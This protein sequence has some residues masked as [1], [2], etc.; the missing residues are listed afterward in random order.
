MNRSLP[1]IPK[2]WIQQARLADEAAIEKIY[3]KTYPKAYTIAYYSLG[4]TNKFQDEAQ[5]ITQDSLRKAFEKLSLLK[6]DD[7]FAPWMYTILNNSIRDYFRSNKNKD[8]QTNTFSELDSED[9]RDNYEESI[10]DDSVAFSPEANMNTELIAQ[11]L[12]ECLDQL[13]DNQRFAL[14]MQM[15]QQ[16][17]TKEIAKQ[18]EVEENTVKSWIRRAK[19]SIKDRIEE[20]RSQ[21]KSFYGVA[22]LPF[23]AWMLDQE[24]KSVPTINAKTFADGVVLKIKADTM[25]PPIPKKHTNASTKGEVLEKGTYV[26]KVTTISEGHAKAI[27]S[28]FWKIAAGAAIVTAATVG[29]YV[30]VDKIMSDKYNST[31]ANERISSDQKIT[32]SGR[33][34]KIKSEEY[35]YRADWRAIEDLSSA[36]YIPL[37]NSPYEDDKTDYCLN[38]YLW[39]GD[40]GTGGTKGTLGGIIVHPVQKEDEDGNIWVVIGNVEE[41]GEKYY[42]KIKD[43][44]RTYFHKINENP[45]SYTDYY[46]ENKFKAACG[47]NLSDSI[48][49]AHIEIDSH[50]DFLA[51]TNKNSLVYY[52]G[53][54]TEYDR[55]TQ[56]C[57]GTLVYY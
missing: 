55:Y 54:I 41:D 5:S 9:F 45:T 44:N 24:L 23:L 26:K 25:T 48:E 43:T 19:L 57:D 21:N 38:F 8:Y 14:M 40:S 1:D 28:G 47:V 4:G 51:T 2:E 50:R 39:I 36:R 22:P 17:T 12:R 35:A 20:L 18:M 53:E 31:E 15:Y 33:T 11:G 27:L 49:V 52:N 34:W 13:P 7:K 16:L 46:D 10:A 42:V 37:Y 30:T 3:S 56:L 29:S 6:D 32:D